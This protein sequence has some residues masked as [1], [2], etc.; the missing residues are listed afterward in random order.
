MGADTTFSLGSVIVGNTPLTPDAVSDTI[1]NIATVYY[2]VKRLGNEE[3]IWGL[4][5][6]GFVQPDNAN[7]YIEIKSYREENHGR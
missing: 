6:L 1:A 7:G 4:R 2:D 5:R 3:P